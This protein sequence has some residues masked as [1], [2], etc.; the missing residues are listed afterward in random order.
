MNLIR[1]YTREQRIFTPPTHVDLLELDLTD[2]TQV[3]R[4]FQL[5]CVVFA[6]LHTENNTDRLVVLV[7]ERREEFC[8]LASIHFGFQKQSLLLFSFQVELQGFNFLNY[9]HGCC[10]VVVRAFFFIANE[11]D[12]ERVVVESKVHGLGRWVSAFVCARASFC[13]VPL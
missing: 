5:R 1:L 12:C 9:H 10:F 7:M 3:V 8:S 11:R 13:V 6:L 2:D 4:W